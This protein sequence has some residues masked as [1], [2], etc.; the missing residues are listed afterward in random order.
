M[1][2]AGEFQRRITHIKQNN[3]FMCHRLK[4]NPF[5]EKSDHVTVSNI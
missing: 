1:V 5:Y 4:K 3:L 2:K